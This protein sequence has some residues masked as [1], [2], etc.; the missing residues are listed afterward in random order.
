MGFVTP[1]KQKG[2]FFR[3]LLVLLLLAGLTGCSTFAT[4]LKS[5]QS[6]G[7]KMEKWDVQGYMERKQPLPI[8]KVKPRT[9]Q[10]EAFLNDAKE[11]LHAKQTQF[12]EYLST[13]DAKWT[14]VTSTL[15]GK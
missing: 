2:S 3:G 7:V 6:Q 1:Q 10:Y 9:T 11:Q 15:S 14:E 4:P 12:Q 13:F 5:Q 8:Q